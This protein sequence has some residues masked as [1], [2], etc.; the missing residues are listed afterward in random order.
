MTLK[1]TGDGEGAACA[2]VVNTNGNITGVTITNPGSGYTTASIQITQ[3]SG[4]G[5][6]AAF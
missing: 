2:A 5:T 1:I 4:G 3:A 6:I